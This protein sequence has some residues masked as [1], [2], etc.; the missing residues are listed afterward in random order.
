MQKAA[1]DNHKKWLDFH[2]ENPAVYDLIKHFA[3][4]AIKSGRAHYGINSVIERV[5]WHTTVETG[6]AS[7]KINNNHA[8]FYARL[9]EAEHPEHAGFFRQRRQHER[10]AA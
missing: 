10:S 2:E 5:R 6:G 8:P 9:F 4:I 1:N 7:Y 3:M